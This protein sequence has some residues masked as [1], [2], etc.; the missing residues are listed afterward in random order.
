MLLRRCT[1]PFVVHKEVT[2]LHTDAT[3]HPPPSAQS[4]QLNK[5]RLRLLQRREEHL[6]SLF[7]KAREQLLVLSKDEGRYAQLLEGVILQVSL[8]L[9]PHATLCLVYEGVWLM[10]YV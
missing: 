1:L 9:T 8:I 7:E 10:M 4:T 5:S 2:N 6:Q 3:L